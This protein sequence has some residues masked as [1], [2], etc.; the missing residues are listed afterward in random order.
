MINATWID[1]FTT[2]AEEGHFTRAAQKLNMT[3]PGVSQQLRKLEAQLGQ[4]L[5][6][7]EGKGFVLTEAGEAVRV[8]GL[9]RRAEERALREAI[10]SDDP[11][12]GALRIA[13]SGSFAMAF[14]PLAL[15]MMTAAPRLSIHLEAAPRSRVLAE[16]QE[17]KADL[18]ILGDDPATPRLTAERIGQEELCLLVPA[19]MKQDSFEAL[20]QLG[21]VAHP[22]VYSYA[23]DVLGANFP[24]GFKGAD[25]LRIR[26]SVNQIGQ[27]P[28]PVAAGLGYTLLPRSGL[29][30]FADMDRIRIV[31]LQKP[32][33]QDLWAVTL[34]GRRPTQRLM[35]VMQA[36]RALVNGL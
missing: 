16:V 6:A 14:Y 1:T 2:L 17:G 27:I 33:V 32:Q 7:Q 28:A 10:A 24:E 19:G 13:C 29:A 9:K 15:A 23:E 8:M 35:R 3:Q 30:G 36:V 25:R 21:L 22:D 18:G 20:D 26:T 11:D 4:P 12:A 5:I 31:P 34:R